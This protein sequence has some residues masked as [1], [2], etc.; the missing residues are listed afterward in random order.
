MAL[1]ALVRCHTVVLIAAL[2]SLVAIPLSGRSREQHLRTLP[3][4]F[5]K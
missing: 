4:G 5:T 2:D 1:F 3:R